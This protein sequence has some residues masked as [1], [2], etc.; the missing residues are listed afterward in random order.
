MKTESQKVR[1][2]P[3]KCNSQHWREL[4]STQSQK[5]GKKPHR[6]L[7]F[8]TFCP[9]VSFWCCRRGVCSQRLSSTFIFSAVH[10]QGRQDPP[11]VLKGP[12]NPPAPSRNMPSRTAHLQLQNSKWKLEILKQIQIQ[13]MAH[14]ISKLEKSS[15]HSCQATR[16]YPPSY[17]LQCSKHHMINHLLFSSDDFIHPGTNFQM[18]FM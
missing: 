11:P 10:G 17:C 16:E 2:C 12:L 14:S 15:L 9:T 1:C 4:E 3:R 7:C 6:Y 13:A 5:R 18:Y 8:Y